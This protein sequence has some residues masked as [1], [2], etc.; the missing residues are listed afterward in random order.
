MACSGIVTNW[1]NH[2][3]FAETKSP[4]KREYLARPSGLCMSIYRSNEDN[5][6]WAVGLLLL[7]VLEK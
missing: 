4:I 6:D 3:W 1:K 2:L 5:K 7:N